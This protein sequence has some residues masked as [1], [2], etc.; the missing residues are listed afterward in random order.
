MALAGKGG[1]MLSQRVYRNQDGSAYLVV[2]AAESAVLELLGLADELNL[3][4][5]VTTEGPI[6]LM[7]D[8]AENGPEHRVME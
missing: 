3:R 8:P 4:S 7:N 2:T 5:T 6:H 1:V